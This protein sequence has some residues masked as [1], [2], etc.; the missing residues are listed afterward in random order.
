VKAA[1][2]TGTRRRWWLA[3]SVGCYVLA[4]ASKAI[5]MTLPAV[6][7]VLDVYPLKRVGTRWREWTGRKA[8]AVWLEKVP[9]LL[10]ALA[11]AGAAI[12]AQRSI[13][14][15]LQRPV[16]GRIAVALYGLC[17]YLWKTFI[18]FPPF[19]DSPGDPLAPDD[20]DA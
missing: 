14:E 20:R 18:P 12:Y 17:F 13:A 19:Y 10:V 2:D 11:A 16:V 15:P 9:Y 1:A 7:I 4:V 3:C 5:V 8:R 6:L